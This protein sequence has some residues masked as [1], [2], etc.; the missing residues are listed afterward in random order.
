M[1]AVVTVSAAAIVL[2]D[3]APTSVKKITGTSEETPGLAWSFDPAEYLDRPFAGLTDPR[4]GSSFNSGEPGFILTG[5]TFLTIAGSPTEG[6]AL[7][8]PVMI[9]VDAK[10]GTARWQAPA[11]DLLGCS[12]IPLGGKIYCYAMSDKYEIVTYDIDSGVSE[13]RT[14]P[15]SVYGLTTT[16]DALYIAE[17][18]LE[19]SVEGSDVRVHS[20][21]F[22]NISANW[23]Q[24]VDIG[25]YYEDL[26]GIDVLTVTDGVGLVRIGNQ[27]A[28]FDAESGTPLWT[29]GDGV[30]VSQASL[31]PGGVVAQINSDC[32]SYN[33]VSGQLLRGPDGKVLTT[34]DS[35]TAQRPM[36]EHRDDAGEPI[37]LGDSAYDR[38]SGELLWTNPSIVSGSQ[39]AVTAIVGDTIYLRD[40]N[41]QSDTGIDLRTGKQLWHNDATQ[42]FD[43]AGAGGRMLL[44]NDGTAL[45]EFDLR[46]GSVV[47]TAPFTSIASDPETFATGRAAQR[48]GDGWIYSSDR[49]MIG[50]APL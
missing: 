22:D 16:S 5:D 50:L 7:D 33:S 19:E 37:L 46:T 39:G 34:T 8:K 13:R 4:L 29:T 15:E 17:G 42:T 40:T 43:V 45:T 14:V 48:Y 30:C 6:L 35:A 27:M 49:R 38:S 25:G 26:Y 24:P 47:W 3:R 41:T 20:G 9:S 18:S 21:T 32:D 28:Q 12:D 31:E 2:A 10:D 11:H 36:L 1:T 44:G 23:S